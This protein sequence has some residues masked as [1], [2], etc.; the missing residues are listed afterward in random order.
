MAMKMSAPS[1]DIFSF[2][3][4]WF[5]NLKRSV[6][7]VEITNKQGSQAI[8]RKLD[9]IARQLEDELTKIRLVTVTNQKDVNL[10]GLEKKLTDILGA[11][12]G[13]KPSDLSKVERLLTSLIDS[14][15]GIPQPKIPDIKIPETKFPKS[16]AVDNFPAVQKVTGS[17]EVDFKKVLEGLQVVV[18][19]INDMKLTMSQEMKGGGTVYTGQT[20][21]NREKMKGTT[22]YDPD[23]SAPIYLGTNSAPDADTAI[24]DWEILKFTYSGANVTKIVR[25]VGSW[26]GRTALF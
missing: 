17:V 4:I 9:G 3:A 15:K 18:D 16:M 26:T 8:E 24:G 2:L 14:I 22:L 19:A 12:Q 21:A 5:D 6:F 7:K 23:D 13:V 10:Q 11:L 25:R 1:L 20:G